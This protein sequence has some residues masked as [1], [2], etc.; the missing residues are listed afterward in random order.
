MR[1]YGKKKCSNL[2]NK[3]IIIAL[4]LNVFFLLLVLIFC[5]IK[6]ETSDD[7]V[8]ASIL[9]GAYGNDINQ[10][11]IYINALIGYL[12]T[13]LYKICSIVSWLFIYQIISI[14]LA[15]TTAC[16]I[17]FKR[18]DRLVASMLSLMIILFF[19]N[20]AYILM[21][22]TKT[23]MFSVTTGGILFI[24]ALKYRHFL[25]A[26]V[27]SILCLNGVLIRFSTVFI[28]AG[29]IGYIFIKELFHFVKE[30]KRFC[31]IL[32]SSGVL[33]LLLISVKVFDWYLY[34]NDSAYKFY[35]DYNLTRSQIV[36]YTDYGYDTYAKEVEAIGVTENDYYMLRTWNF[37]DNEVFS[38]EKMR[39]V[40]DIIQKH[41]KSHS[42]T[43]EKTLENLQSREILGYPIFIACIILLFVGIV[44][45]DKNWKTMIISFLIG[46]LY[47][48][49]FLAVRERCIYRIE[50][51][52]FL[53][54]FLTGAYFW[55]TDTGK[56]KKENR[57]YYYRIIA[58]FCIPSLILYIPDSSYKKVNS[59]N[60]KQYI[61]S[62]FDD[63]WGLEIQKYRKV[64]NKNKPLNGLLEEIKNNKQN[65]YF[66]NFG[67]TIQSLYFDTSP[68]EALPIG[69][70]SNFMY[71]SGITSNFPDT[72][73]ILNS[74]GLDNPLKNLVNDNVYLVDNENLGIKLTYLREHYYSDTQ[75]DLYKEVDGYQIWKLYTNSN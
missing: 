25:H 10:R 12:L 56:M 67:T 21:Q 62:V 2:L 22:Y 48:V 5:D 65:S 57:K 18:T 47:L 26:I 41:Y 70:Y 50:F 43:L 53:G 13:P 29:F 58:I 39:Q 27:G 59:L 14:F 61:D 11:M 46:I 31:I 7:F 24:W 32:L 15:S 23:A 37:A 36:D 73:N 30:K 71:L 42:I 20:D 60:R 28:A 16:Y 63:S 52:I 45:N 8:I 4:I 34:H 40:A 69:Y 33:C 51:C 64:V 3:E 74:Y 54:I 38:L 1:E 75:A 55:N 17:F 19:T 9:S 44:L 49:Y 35:Y 66:L 68:W 72:L 6:Y